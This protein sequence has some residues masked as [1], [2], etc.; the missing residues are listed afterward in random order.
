MNQCVR[1]LL[2]LVDEEEKEVVDDVEEVDEAVEAV[3]EDEEEVPDEILVDKNIVPGLS[4]QESFKMHVV[5]H[6][7]SVPPMFVYCF[8]VIC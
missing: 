2:R 8:L 3:D 1:S 4:K 5:V 6:L 7:V